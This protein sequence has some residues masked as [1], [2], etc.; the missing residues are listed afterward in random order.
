MFFIFTFIISKW[1]ILFASREVP[2]AALPSAEAI[3]IRLEAAE[4]AIRRGPRKTGPARAVDPRKHRLLT[5][6]KAAS[7]ENEIGW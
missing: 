2:S 1:T 5:A 3:N 6:I 7:D 4:H